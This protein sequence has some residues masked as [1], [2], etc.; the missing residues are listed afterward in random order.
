MRSETQGPDVLHDFFDKKK[1]LYQLLKIT[2]RCK[3]ENYGLNIAGIT[4]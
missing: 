2:P 3:L 4:G 1:Y